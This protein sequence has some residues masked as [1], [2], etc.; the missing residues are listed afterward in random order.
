MYYL[1]N[2]QKKPFPFSKTGKRYHYLLQTV[3]GYGKNT[4][5]ATSRMRSSVI[6]QFTSH[7]T[8][9]KPPT[10]SGPHL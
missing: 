6:F 4:E 5:L 1:N 10:I 8:L 3:R 9:G 7:M 2:Q